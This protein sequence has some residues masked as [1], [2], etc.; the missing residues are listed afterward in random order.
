[1]EYKV[2]DNV[3]GQIKKISMNYRIEKVVLFGSRAREDNLPESD[4][5]IAVFGNSLTAVNKACFYAEVEEINTLKKIDV[6]FVNN[7]S[8]DELVKNIMRD[9]VVIYEQVENC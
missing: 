6:V 5:D 1:M 7:S 4:Y 8:K 3:I 9:G 2:M